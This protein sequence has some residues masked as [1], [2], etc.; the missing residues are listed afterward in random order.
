VYTN[1]IDVGSITNMSN[2]VRKFELVTL[3]F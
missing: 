2:K 3:S 1:R